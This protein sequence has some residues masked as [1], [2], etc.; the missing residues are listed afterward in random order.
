[1]RIIQFGTARSGSTLCYN[2]IRSILPNAV[3]KKTHS[4]SWRYGLSPVIATTRDPFDSVAS[5]IV[6]R[7][8]AVSDEAVAKA[9]KELF[10]NGFSTLHRVRLFPRA[11]LLHYED[12]VGN[13]A[14]LLD[15][16][17]Q[18]FG[19]YVHRRVKDEFQH[20]FDATRI[21]M[22]MLGGRFGEYDKETLFHGSHVSARL[23]KPGAGEALSTRQKQIV[24]NILRL[25][26]CDFYDDN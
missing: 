9:A 24:S 3:I 21:R 4:A 25:K 8:D 23:G 15:S 11:M 10:Q 20:R 16:V 1:M 7:N 6:A 14:M 18:F 19:V 12:F 26:K 13:H 17:A 5:L 22:E 2:A